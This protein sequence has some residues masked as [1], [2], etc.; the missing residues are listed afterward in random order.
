MPDPK[1]LIYDVEMSFNVSYHYDQWGVNI[2]HTHI[3][4]TQFMI[5]AA[6]RWFGQKKIHAVSVLDDP[7]RFEKD[8]RDDYHVINTLR[9]QIDQADATVAFNG[10]RFDTKEFNTGL[11]K[12]NFQPAHDYVQ[13]DPIK[14]AKRKF[15]FKGGNSLDNL[16]KFLNLN[17]QKGHVD[18]KDWIAATEG[19]PKAIRKIVKYNKGDIPTLE[20]VWRKV[21]PFAPSQL[22]MN[23]FVAAD[24]CS[25]CGGANLKLHYRR[26]AA[27]AT[28]RYQFQCR[29][30]GGYTTTG[31]AIKS[32][33]FR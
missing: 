26:K 25:H 7:K 4:H 6:W 21:K 11:I 2:P 28:V 31:K 13:I 22:N 5:S 15:R 32:E 8:F 23:H 12:H 16:C 19:D 29:D 17:V 14:I 24:V 27:R 18:L 9:E 20:A 1:I 33:N 3:K 10:D 30:C